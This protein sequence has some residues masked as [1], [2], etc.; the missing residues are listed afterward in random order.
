[1]QVINNPA[2]RGQAACQCEAVVLRV[3]WSL[4]WQLAREG[5][6]GDLGSKR[7]LIWPEPS[8][9]RHVGVCAH[10]NVWKAHYGIQFPATK[11]QARVSKD[12][13]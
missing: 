4:K 5:T 1:M 10:Q 12:N 11:H 7:G 2:E 8:V 6:R 9:Y 13:R 3:C